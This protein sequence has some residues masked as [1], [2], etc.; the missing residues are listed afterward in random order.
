MVFCLTYTINGKAVVVRTEEWK[1]D[2]GIRKV[3]QK[4]DLSLKSKHKGFS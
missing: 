1:T 3:I 2:G 4:Q